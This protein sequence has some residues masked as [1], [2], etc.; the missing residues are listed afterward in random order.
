M[1]KVEEIEKLKNLLDEGILSREQYNV[2][3]EDIIGHNQKKMSKEEQLLADGAITKEQFDILTKQTNSSESSDE[4][5]TD[6][7]DEW[8]SH[9]CKSILKQFFD[10]ERPYE[11]KRMELL[12]YSSDERKQLIFYRLCINETLPINSPLKVNALDE[13]LFFFDDSL[14]KNAKGGM[15][16][17][18]KAIFYSAYDDNS[19][20]YISWDCIYDIHEYYARNNRIYFTFAIIEEYD[21]EAHVDESDGYIEVFGSEEEMLSIASLFDRFFNLKGSSFRSVGYRRFNDLPD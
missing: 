21:V 10:S 13:M 1:S 4:V 14:W 6:K 9:D 12:K 2:L 17:T 20:H 3:L 5:V 8:K 19:T 7:D 16:I 18:N 11:N 15:L